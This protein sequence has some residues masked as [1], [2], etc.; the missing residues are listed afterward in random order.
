MMYAETVNYG[1]N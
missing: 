1:R